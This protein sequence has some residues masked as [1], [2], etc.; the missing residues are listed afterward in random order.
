MLSVAVSQT[1]R[2]KSLAVIIDSHR[3]KHNLIPSIH[4]HIGNGKIMIAITKPR[5]RPS[6]IV[7]PI[8]KLRQLVSGRINVEGCHLM[9]R[10]ATA[11]QENAWFMPIQ[12]RSTEI[13]LHRA[14]STVVL[15]IR[16]TTP[17]LHVSLFISRS[18]ISSCKF[19]AFESL[20]R[21]SH[22]LLAALTNRIEFARLAVH[23]EQV[24]STH[25][26]VLRVIDLSSIKVWSV[27]NCSGR[28]ISM[29]N[30]DV[31]CTTHQHLCL[32]VHIPVES[33]GIPLLIGTCHHVWSQ[34]NPPEQFT[35][36]RQHL[37]AVESRRVAR[38]SQ[39]S[40]REITFHN[41]F[42]NTITRHV[43]RHS[44]VVFILAAYII[45]STVVS[46]RTRD[47]QITRVPSRHSVIIEILRPAL[48][49]RTLLTLNTSH[50]GRHLVRS[51]CVSCRVEEIGL[52]Q[53]RRQQSTVSIQVVGHIVIFLTEFSPAH[54]ITLTIRSNR[55]HESTVQLVGKT[56][57]KGSRN[58]SP[59]HQHHCNKS[60]HE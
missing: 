46:G 14:V 33:N 9:L 49:S 12:I 17:N 11:S 3:T 42:W 55:C 57:S 38:L 21:I 40:T 26:S 31:V 50:H 29:M 4:I 2:G 5:V 16:C 10:V 34:V 48:D 54:E 13:V 1:S 60:F 6:R 25:T 53:S 43:S 44:I 8:P 18:T 15:S 30:N 19:I 28:T 22:P 23:V 20:Q 39:C 51:R 45:A 27:T 35:F 37:Y 36:Q 7:V 24:F 47:S 58:H 52:L 32:A 56:L 41:Q 59:C